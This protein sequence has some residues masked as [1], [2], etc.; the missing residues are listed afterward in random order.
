MTGST[1]EYQYHLKDH[2]GNVRVTF[3]SKDETETA[4]ATLE[5]ANAGTEQGQ[6]LNYEEA[7]TVNERLFDHTHRTA[8]NQG[9]T[10]WRSTR[11]L[12]GSDSNAIYGLAKTL[13]VMPGDKI[14]A[15]VYAKYVDASAPDVQQALLT[16]L[17]ALGTG[18]AGDPLI[19]GGSPGSLGGSIFPYPGYLEREDDGGTAPKAY[20]NYLVFDRDFNFLN[21][22]YK[23]LTTN[24]RETGNVL[25]EGVGHDTLAFEEGEIK[26]TEPG[27]VYIYFSNENES[28]VEVFFDDFEVTHKKSPVVQQD[29]YYPF[30]LVYNSYSREN[31]VKNRHLYNQGTGDK[32]FNTERVTDLGL[33]IDLTKYRVYDPA[34]GRWWQVDPKTDDLYDWTPYNY[35]FNNPILYSDPEGDIPPLVWGILAVVSL[36]LD[37]EFA[38]APGTDQSPAAQQRAQ[39][40]R[41]YLRNVNESVKTVVNPRNIVRKVVSQPIRNG[42][43]KDLSSKKQTTQTPQTLEQRAE[44]LN[45]TPRPGKDHTKAGKEVVKEQNAAKNGGQT[46]C[47][48]C[49]VTTVPAKKHETGVTPPGNETHVDHT[50]PKSPA[51]PNV[52]PGSGTPDN[53]R[54]LCR[55]CN[56]KKS[57]N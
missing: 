24:A 14:T 15:K 4:T 23:P 32:K 26:I 44:K 37:A 49:G 10:T 55:D 36:V 53:G 3:T 19:D 12:G 11:L 51:D 46:Q 27:F 40:N 22:G 39:E 42:I 56:L 9:N 8:G 7:V 18:G 20:L 13:S 38:E 54:V 5:D 34:I 21:G 33:N 47:E 25:P 6:F 30:G 35:A 31:S 2:L 43:K 1:P 45:K 16:F 50:V 28:R 29:D 48:E 41:E 52:A 57:N 17:T